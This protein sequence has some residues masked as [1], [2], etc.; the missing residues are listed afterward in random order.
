VPA[1]CKHVLMYAMNSPLHITW[2]M[3]HC[4]LSVHASPDQPLAPLPHTSTGE[5]G[6]PAAPLPLSSGAEDLMGHYSFWL[7]AIA[8]LLSLLSAQFP[9]A[10]HQGLSSKDQASVKG[11]QRGSYKPSSIAARLLADIRGGISAA[12]GERA[13]STAAA[14]G[15]LASIGEQGAVLPTAAAAKLADIQQ[16]LTSTWANF[17]KALGK[18]RGMAPTQSGSSSGPTV[19]AAPATSA[20]GELP[21]PGDVQPGTAKSTGAASADISHHSAHAGEEQ[22]HGAEA[23]ALMRVVSSGS[24]VVGDMVL[25]DSASLPAEGDNGSTVNEPHGDP[26]GRASSAD[27][28]LGRASSAGTGAATPHSATQQFVHVLGQQ[29]QQC[30]AQVGAAAHENFSWVDVVDS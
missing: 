19:T 24:S 1:G 14:T 30:Y 13:G 7:C 8:T 17:S 5:A 6:A 15:P 2:F 28:T 20:S 10:F 23:D 25:V 3:I 26:I 27:G 21:P 12:T 11:H 16:K 29:L 4:G 22:S 18:G 9:A